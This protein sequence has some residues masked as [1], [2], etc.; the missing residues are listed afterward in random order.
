[1][2]AIEDLQYARNHGPGYLAP[3]QSSQS[4][5]DPHAL[6]NSYISPSGAMGDAFANDIGQ[7]Q[8]AGFSAIPGVTFNLNGDSFVGATPGTSLAAALD[9]FMAP[10][11]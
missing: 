3:G 1:M 5:I 6:A 10:A 11:D 8:V 9:S 2:A 4:P 7:Q